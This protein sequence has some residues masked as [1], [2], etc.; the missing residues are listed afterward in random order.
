MSDDKR[1]DGSG[2]LDSSL[3]DLLSLAFMKKK[4]NQTKSELDFILGDEK[5]SSE[6][7]MEVTGNGSDEQVN[8][9]TSSYDVDEIVAATSYK[10]TEPEEEKVYISNVRK[11][12]PKADGEYDDFEDGYDG[13][14]EYYDED[15]PFI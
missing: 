7:R 13:E 14:E 4:E 6:S 2:E 12:T 3:E 9:D 8:F 5:K 10:N 11:I 15:D 1:L